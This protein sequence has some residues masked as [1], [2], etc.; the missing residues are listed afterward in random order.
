MPSGESAGWVR[1][2]VGRRIAQRRREKWELEGC[3][4]RTVMA[5][6]TRLRTTHHDSHTISPP[7]PTDQVA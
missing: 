6:A 7:T 3:C 4:V 5:S 2:D 1:S